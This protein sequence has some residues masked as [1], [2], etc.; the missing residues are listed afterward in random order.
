MKHDTGLGTAKT[1]AIVAAASLLCWSTSLCSLFLTLCAY[2]AVMVLV[3]VVSPFQLRMS[4]LF[5]SSFLSHRAHN[6]RL[7]VKHTQHA[8]TVARQREHRKGIASHGQ[9]MDGREGKKKAR[10]HEGILD[11][12]APSLT[13]FDGSRFKART[14]APQVTRRISS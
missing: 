7:A 11:G 6:A 10:Q 2:C 3:N 8:E 1:M 13:W 9:Q 12:G 14:H 5:G 4:I